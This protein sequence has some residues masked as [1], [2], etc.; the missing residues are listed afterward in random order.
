MNHRSCRGGCTGVAAGSARSRRALCSGSTPAQT[1]RST[2]QTC[3]ALTAASI[4]VLSTVRYLTAIVTVHANVA[5]APSIVP[6]AYARAL[7]WCNLTRRKLLLHLRSH[8]SSLH[9]R[10]VDH[11]P[12]R[13][14]TAQHTRRE[15]EQWLLLVL[16]LRSA[17][18]SAAPTSVS[19]AP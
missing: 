19:E 1:R 5:R 7:A 3:A 14:G 4:F 12:S 13:L 18:R 17:R 15:S 9:S 6:F 16:Q 8:P 10:C 2:T 11:L